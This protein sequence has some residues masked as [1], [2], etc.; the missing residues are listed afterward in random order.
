MSTSEIGF[1]GH[2]AL[3]CET[4]TTFPLQ[5]VPAGRR[6]VITE[7]WVW[8]SFQRGAPLIAELRAVLPSSGTH[9][10]LTRI[11]IADRQPFSLDERAK[12]EAVG[13][14]V[15]TLFFPRA[16]TK[17]DAAFRVRMRRERLG[18]PPANPPRLT[19]RRGS[20]GKSSRMPRDKKLEARDE[21]IYNLCCADNPKV[22]HKTIVAK[23]RECHKTK[24]WKMIESIQGIRRA[25]TEYAERHG[26]P[27]PPRRQ[28]L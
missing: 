13:P 27:P 12:I 28:G 9:I 10:T 5:A 26:L 22:P 8:A 17:T 1:N 15:L 24:G 19:G 11:P 7:L 18:L 20:K 16:H 14:V 4:P 21:W 23:L 3:S 6:Y 25:A 2:I